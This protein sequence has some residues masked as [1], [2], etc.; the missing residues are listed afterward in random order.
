MRVAHPTPD[1]ATVGIPRCPPCDLPAALAIRRSGLPSS[2]SP[3]AHTDSYPAS[4]SGEQPSR[5][6]PQCSC[7]ANSWRGRLRRCP[8]TRRRRS[9]SRG[10]ADP[11][12]AG[13]PG[14]LRHRASERFDQRAR[15]PLAL[16]LM[17]QFRQAVVHDVLR[18]EAHPG[19]P[20]GAASCW[21]NGPLPVPSASWG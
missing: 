18:P 11:A 12:R 15:R 14:A 7:C 17:S 3:G 16:P 19:I 21:T 4:L 13:A 9:R 6:L 1:T 8:L 5:S 10:S 20:V 2:P